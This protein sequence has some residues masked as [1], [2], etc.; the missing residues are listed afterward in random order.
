MLALCWVGLIVST[1]F[2]IAVVAG[3]ITAAVHPGPVGEATV[4]HCVDHGTGRYCYGTFRSGDGTI[5]WADV[6]IWGEDDARVAQRI[7]A[8]A[9]RS[10][11]DVNVGGSAENLYFDVIVPSI[12]LGW[13]IFLFRI[14]IW[15][16]LRHRPAQSP[17]RRPLSPFT[18]PSK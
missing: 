17:D 10:N 7:T 2:I 11:H 1:I 14:C 5:R 3:A 16:P 9:D 13:W 15:K 12:G 8:H 6:R 4:T 18:R